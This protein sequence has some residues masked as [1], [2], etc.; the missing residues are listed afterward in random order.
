MAE[1]KGIPKE[2]IQELDVKKMEKEEIL[3]VTATVEGHQ[4]KL[5]VPSQIRLEVDFK[6]GQRVTVR[7]NKKKR[8]I[9]YNL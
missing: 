6:K 2:V 7:Y 9:I 5:P 8:Q 3:K 1:N 4:V